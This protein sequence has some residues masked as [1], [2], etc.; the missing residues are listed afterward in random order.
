[1]LDVYIHIH[2]ITCI[3][4]PFQMK[5]YQTRVFRSPAGTLADSTI[6]RGSTLMKSSTVMINV[7]RG[8]HATSLLNVVIPMVQVKTFY[9]PSTIIFN[10]GRKFMQSTVKCSRPHG[11]SKTCYGPSKMIFIVERGI[12]ANLQ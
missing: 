1:M 11:P 4:E 6:M 9:G 10:V 2:T 7:E 8:P 5:P 12:Y 3:Y